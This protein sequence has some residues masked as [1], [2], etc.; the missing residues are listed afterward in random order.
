MGLHQFRTRNGLTETQQTRSNSSK[1]A[2]RS[3]KPI[4]IL[5]LITVWLQ[6]RV[7]PGP[8]MKTI[9]LAKEQIFLRTA[10]P[11][12]VHRNWW[13]VRSRFK[14]YTNGEGSPADGLWAK[15]PGVRYIARYQPLFSKLFSLIGG[16][17]NSL[18]GIF[19]VYQKPPIEARSASTT[20]P[21]GAQDEF[22]SG[23]HRSESATAR[24]AGHAATTTQAPC[25]A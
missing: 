14:F 8:P 22:C 10:W 2:G 20:C 23:R 18:G 7:L 21:Q 12:I 9:I 15:V 19:K 4:F 16:Q 1:T 11:Q 13:T 6:V 25:I 17:P 3:T 5:P 24:I